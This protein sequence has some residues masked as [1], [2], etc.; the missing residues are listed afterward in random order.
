MIY[1]SFRAV[2]VAVAVGVA[3][4]GGGVAVAVAVAVGVAV[5]GGGVAVGVS[6]CIAVGVGRGGNVLICE[7]EWGRVRVVIGGVVVGEKGRRGE[8]GGV[9]KKILPPPLPPS[10]SFLKVMES[11]APSTGATVT[12]AGPAIITLL[13]IS[14]KF[15]ELLPV[16]KSIRMAV[17]TSAVPPFS[18]VK[19]TATTPRSI[20]PS[21]EKFLM[22]RN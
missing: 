12:W 6:G 5:R 3:V 20:P 18:P 11:V 1:Y 2:A 4:R 9:G 22:L 8:G 17:R 21:W 13:P 16:L 10:D 19:V 7:G 15:C 14:G